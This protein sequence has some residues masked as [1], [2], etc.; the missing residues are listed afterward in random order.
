MREVEER[1]EKN[2]T[3]GNHLLT[4]YKHSIMFPKVWQI[5]PSLSWLDGSYAS[6]PS[7]FFP[8]CIVLSL[9]REY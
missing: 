7:A 4:E 2:T 3:V 1:E 5:I 6:W 8:V 9:Q